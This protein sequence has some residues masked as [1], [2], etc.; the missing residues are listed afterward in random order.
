MSIP[1]SGFREKDWM[2]MKRGL[3]S[4][5]AGETPSILCVVAGTEPRA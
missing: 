3:N 2:E 1:S 4:T 5:L